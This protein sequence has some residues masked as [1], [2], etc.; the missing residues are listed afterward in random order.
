MP[1]ILARYVFFVKD[2]LPFM[3]FECC[4]LYVFD[5][6]PRRRRR[7]LGAGVLRLLVAT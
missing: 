6:F 7:V 1:D 5:C 3:N 4:L 2:F